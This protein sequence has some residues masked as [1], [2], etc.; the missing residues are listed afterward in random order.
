[1][2]MSSRLRHMPRVMS[3][4]ESSAPHAQSFTSRLTALRLS[5]M[6]QGGGGNKFVFA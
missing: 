3:S 4:G 1:M 5:T 2:G 6:L